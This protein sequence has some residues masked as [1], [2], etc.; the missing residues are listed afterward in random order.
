MQNTVT[1]IGSISSDILATTTQDGAPQAAFRLV[2][3]SSRR[4]RATGTWINRTPSFLNVRCTRQLARHVHASLHRGDPVIVTGRL[5]VVQSKD[6]RL[7]RVEID[8]VCIAP[9]LN[10]VQVSLVRQAAT[11]AA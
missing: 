2:T 8:A 7:S 4:D 11:S 10:R 9:D 5:R 6:S 3:Y 1:L